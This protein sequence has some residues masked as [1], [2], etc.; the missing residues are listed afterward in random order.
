MKAKFWRASAINCFN[1][2]LLIVFN[3]DQ[4]LSQ[5]SSSYL[6]KSTVIHRPQ[7]MIKMYQM[8]LIFAYFTSVNIYFIVNVAKD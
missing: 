7:M 4:F 6:P 2:N 3:E 5:F 8:K 1:V